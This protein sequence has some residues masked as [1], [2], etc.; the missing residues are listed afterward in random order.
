MFVAL[1]D[2]VPP[3]E[4]QERTVHGA[5]AP[6]AYA[7]TRPP[8]GPSAAIAGPHV[9]RGGRR[10]E[11]TRHCRLSAGTVPTAAGSA[12]IE[13]GGTKIL[14]SIFGPR[15]ATERAQRE[16]AAEGLLAVDL[17]FA[18][19]CSRDGTRE[20]N[21]KRA[22]LYNATLQRAL[23]SLV[24]LERYAR[25]AFDVHLLVLEDDGAVLTAALAVACLALADATV[26]M[27]DLAAGA[28]VHLAAAASGKGG[29]GAAAAEPQLLLDCDGEEERRLPE[30]SAV[31]HLGLCAARGSVCLLHSAGPLPLAHLE[32]MVAL[33][34]GT[35]EA[36]GA[37]MRRCLER[38]AEEQ[39]P[40]TA[41]RARLSDRAVAAALA[42]MPGQEEDFPIV[43]D[44]GYD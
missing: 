18:P 39:G 16:A 32:R 43:L 2:P 29:G 14:A 41:K 20:G 34:K 6:L 44:D 1:G 5:L 30:G 9:R 38:R 17:S 7:P 10:P 4:R 11:E 28:S 27:R 42:E 8:P 33:A 3:N 22:V 40:Q 23:E 15:Q 35:A 13:Q 19:F 25:T 24:L 37:E 26:E 21:E 36:V 12:Y 31:V